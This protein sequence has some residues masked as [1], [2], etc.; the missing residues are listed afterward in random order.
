M[1]W[2]N[3]VSLEIISL[4]PPETVN[5]WLLIHCHMFYPTIGKS[6]LHDTLCHHA[7]RSNLPQVKNRL[8]CGAGSALDS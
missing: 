8:L 5:N 7:E 1:Q 6:Q 4:N 2:K 3:S